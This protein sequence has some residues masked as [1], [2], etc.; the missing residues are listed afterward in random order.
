MNFLNKRSRF[1]TV[2]IFT[3]SIGSV[4]VT[5]APNVTMANNGSQIA[6]ANVAQGTY[7]VI[8]HQISITISGVGTSAILQGMQCVTTGSYVV[9]DI[10]ALKVIYSTNSTLDAGDVTLSSITPA[11][12]GTQT[13]TSWTNQTITN[14]STGYIFITAD[15]YAGAVPGHTISVNAL[16]TTDLTWNWGNLFGSSTAGGLQT[17]TGSVYSL[18]YVVTNT[19]DNGGV[20]PAAGAGTGTLRQAIVDANAHAGADLIT[21]NLGA[22][23]PYTITLSAP[24]VVQTDNLGVT[25]HGWTNTGNNGTQNTNAIFTSGLNP[26]YKV[27][28]TGTAAGVD[29]LLSLTSNNNVIKGIVFQ[30]CASAGKLISIAGA[31]NQILGCYIGMT[32]GGVTRGASNSTYGVYINNVANNIIGDG[33]RAGA[34][35]ISG[36]DNRGAGVYITGASATGNVIKGNII[37]LQANGTTLVASNNQLY[38]VQITS[39]AGGNTIGGTGTEDGNLISGQYGYYGNP[40]TKYYGAGVF[41]NSTAAAGNTVIGNRIGPQRDGA[42]AV[43]SNTQ[44]YGI[45]ISNSRNN[46]IGGNS[47][48]YRNVISANGPIASTSFPTPTIWTAGI[49]VQGASSTGNT[50][51]GNYIGPSADGTSYITSAEQYKGIRFNSAGTGNTVGGTAAGEGNVISGN[52]CDFGG[53]CGEGRGIMIYN[54]SSVTIVGNIIGLQADGNTLLVSAPTEKQYYGIE[55]DSAS[56]NN[57]IGGNIAGARNIISGNSNAGIEIDDIYPYGAGSTGNIIKGNYIGLQSDGLTQVASNIQLYGVVLNG[58]SGNTVGGTAL[59]ERNIISG[60]NS[61]GI[62]LGSNSNTITR[63]I[64]GLSKNGT[65]VSSSTQFYGISSQACSSNI[66]G[67]NS[68]SY[69]NVISGN[70]SAGI[71]FISGAGSGNLIK[72]NYIGTDTT[73]ATVM[74]TQGTGIYLQINGSNTIGGSGAGEGNVISGNSTGISLNSSNSNTI[75]RNIIGPQ[76]NGT[77]LVAGNPQSIGIYFSDAGSNTVGNTTSANKNII[78]GNNLYGVYLSGSLSSSNIFQ[79]NYIGPG[80]GL[81]A[82]GGSAQINGFY[83]FNGA[84]NN[85]IGGTAGGEPNVI[86]YNTG[87]GIYML[88]TTCTGNKIS[89]N[90]IY[91]N[92]ASGKQINLNYGVNQGNN[93]RAVPLLTTATTATIAGATSPACISCTVEIFKNTTGGAYDASTY[94]SS[95]T[96]DGA[97][98]WTKAVALSAGDRVMATVT[99]G[100]NNTSEFSSPSNPLPVELLSFSAEC[101][102]GNEVICRWETAMETS[103][104]FFTVER[105]STPGGSWFVLGTVKGAGNSSTVHS[106]LFEDVMLFPSEEEISPLRYYRLKQTDFNGQFEYFKPASVFCDESKGGLNVFPNPANS[107]D[108]I[109]MTIDGEKEKQILV[110]LYDVEGRETFSKLFVKEEGKNLYTMDLEGKIAPGIYFIKAS[111][112]DHTLSKKIV[113]K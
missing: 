4:Q 74:G 76:T 54:T 80:S 9:A 96:S 17:I 42:T 90:P 33:T 63:N 88:M 7:P 112:D 14:P 93:G 32:S 62:V 49:L 67:G 45:F 65:V 30:N 39:T 22:A 44:H 10:A 66:I 21:F 16:A 51:K 56:S 53:N 43:A 27:I 3:I 71:Y 36:N 18:T 78:S 84:S 97:G 25:I 79:G 104:D 38:G 50:I 6:A 52:R 55:I 77:S 57:I 103:N 68:S 69:R 41:L 64:L 113:V 24:L 106:Y 8:L 46:T 47:S 1:L 73:G 75:L 28:I 107:S 100:S 15:I 109:N 101:G 95:V 89:G 5:A 34:N 81:A 31:S 26:V 40:G 94:V 86:A 111:S 58:G 82:V 12:A 110:V 60:N 48:S 59:G 23:G 11:V 83:F 108:N 61:S 29:P 98:N 99:D 92:N 13:F 35:L 19:G 20:N 105:T 2:L 85:T 72:G 87:D 91:S 37:G 70:S 102:S